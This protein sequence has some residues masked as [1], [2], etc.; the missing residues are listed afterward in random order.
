MPS[1]NKLIYPQLETR[2][3]GNIL[4]LSPIEAEIVSLL[5][6]KNR[7]SI[8]DIAREL[9]RSSSTISKYVGKLDAAAIVEI[10]GSEPP[11]KFVCLVK[12]EKP[13]K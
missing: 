5:E 12:E 1:T 3:L 11:R 2:R 4:K 6:K 7:L 9:K 10:D 13:R 8:I